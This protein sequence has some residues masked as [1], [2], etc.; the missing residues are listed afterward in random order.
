[1]KK[2][3]VM[4][5]GGA[6]SATALASAVQSFKTYAI[7]FDYGQRSADFELAAARQ[8]AREFDVSLETVDVTGLKRL[9]L[10]LTPEA[11]IPLGFKTSGGGGGVGNC[12]H[13]LFGIASTYCVSA[14]IN[15]LVSG[16]HKDDIAGLTNPSGY[17][18]QWGV[19]ISE[20][21]GVE[22]EFS[23][24]FIE[25]EKSEILTMGHKLG[26]PFISTRSCSA[27]GTQHCGICEPCIKRQKAFVASSLTDPT[28][29]LG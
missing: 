1:M 5:S 20:L 6:D 25:M 2:A 10:G 11:V 19:G 21:Q 24:P 23:L 14:G 12:P 26:V 15:L 28:Q 3:L 17:F 13:G 9:F 27:D 16:L 8:I 4:L 29:Y 22:F 7:F 18:R